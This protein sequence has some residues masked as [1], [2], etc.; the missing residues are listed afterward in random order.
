MYVLI[1]LFSYQFQVW[2]LFVVVFVPLLVFFF[3]FVF[4]R[5]EVSSYTFSGT[6]AIF[7]SIELYN[8]ARGHFAALTTD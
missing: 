6:E 5:S 3:F 2:L 8:R 1:H 7:H 4:S